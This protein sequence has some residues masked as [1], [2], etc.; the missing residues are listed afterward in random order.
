M[1][2]KGNNKI[3]ELRTILQYDDQKKK[4]QRQTIIHKTLH[5]KN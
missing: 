2:N 4:R 3:T 1:D 5:R